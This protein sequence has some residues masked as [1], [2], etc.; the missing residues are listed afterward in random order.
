MG[1][2]KT[3]ID[4]RAKR[5]QRQPALQVPFL[6]R[7]FRA[8]Q[9][10]SDTNLDSLTSET[11]GRVHRLAHGAAEGDTLFELQ[12]NRFGDELRVQ[13][14]PVDFLDVNVNFAFRALL[15]F[16]LE[17][18]DFRA[19][20]SN[21]DSRTGREQANHELVGGAFDID[22]TDPGGAQFVFQLFAQGNVLVQQVFF[23]VI[24]LPP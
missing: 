5:L 12:C 8:V 23:F 10:A 14:R 24:R 11:Q 4:V 2:G 20:A 6:A 21:D 9:T 1:L 22:R 15:D 17:L 19:F 16:S 3:K 18:V 7:D 13:F